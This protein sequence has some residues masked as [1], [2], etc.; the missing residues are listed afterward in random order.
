MDVLNETVMKTGRGY[1]GMAKRTQSQ[2]V[3]GGSDISEE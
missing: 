1:L 2:Y 3:T